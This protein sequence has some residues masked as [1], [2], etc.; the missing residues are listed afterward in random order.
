MSGV[1]VYVEQVGGDVAAITRELL[2]KGRALADALGGPLAALVVGA[3]VGGLAERAIAFGAD[4]VYVVS[5]PALASYTTDGYVAAAKAVAEQAQPALILAG[6]SF[7]MRDFGAALAADLGAGLAADAI[8]I[9]AEGGQ[10]SAVRPSHGGNVINT[11]SFAAGRAAVVLAR[12]QSFPEAPEQ[13]GRSGSV[14]A[15]ALPTTAI[16]TTVTGVAPK[17]GAVNLTDAAIIVSG[18]R[19]LGNK[20]N[21]Y[22]LIPPLAESLGAAYGASRAVV[23]D[24]WVPYEHQVGQTGKTVS[25]KL[26]VACGISGA[27]QHLAGMRTSRSIVAI[28]KDP[29]APIFRVATYGLVGDVNEVLPLLTE[30]LKGR[31][32]R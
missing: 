16:R 9:S 1:L 10:I 21:Y 5:D 22:K 25:P 4:T 30:Q 14:E 27:I 2:G 8:D 15:V 3:E 12:K 24:G 29:E 6:A 31:L 20:D 32:S 17:S 7:Q 28:N 13:A 11:Y 19:G 26:Y 18:G 23:D